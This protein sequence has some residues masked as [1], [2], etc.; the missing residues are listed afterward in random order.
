[1]KIR[2]EKKVRIEKVFVVLVVV[3]KNKAHLNNELA[4]SQDDF[5]KKYRGKKT[6]Y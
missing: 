3:L 6:H 2:V 4:K 1:M 5:T